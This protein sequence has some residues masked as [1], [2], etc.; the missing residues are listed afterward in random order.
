MRSKTILATA[1]AGALAAPLAAYA[2]DDSYSR[3]PSASASVGGASV[4]GSLGSSDRSAGAY[5]QDR[6]DRYAQNDDHDNGRHRGRDKHRD[7]DRDRQASSQQYGGSSN[8]QSTQSEY[9][10]PTNRQYSTNNP[11]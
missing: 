10:S 2:D 4:Q 6:N 5:G 7:K 1:L 11:Y 9:P 8:G 3:S